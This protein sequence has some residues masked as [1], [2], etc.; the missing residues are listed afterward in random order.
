MEEFDLTAWSPSTSRSDSNVSENSCTTPTLPTK[1]TTPV[2]SD[3]FA[4]STI[5]LSRVV[6]NPT[7]GCRKRSAHLETAVCE[8]LDSLKKIR[9]ERETKHM[10]IDEESRFSDTVADTLRKLPGKLKSEA[11]FSIH[12]ILF[13]M[14]QKLYENNVDQ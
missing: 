6:V 1:P 12:K 2:S 11:K 9:E 4:P 3:P 14:E 10:K 7:K 5:A 13:E 8:R